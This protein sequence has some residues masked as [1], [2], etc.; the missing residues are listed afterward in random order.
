MMTRYEPVEAA[1]V[2]L[3]RY[4]PKASDCELWWSGSGVRTRLNCNRLEAEIE[5][6]DGPQTPW[7]VVTADGAPVARFPLT[8]GRHRYA[9]LGD[10]GAE[11]EHEI[12]LLRDTEPSE[13]DPGPVKLLAL[14]TDGVP[15]APTARERLVEFIGDSL[16]AGEGTLGPGSAREWRRAW[17]SGQFAFPAMAAELLN[18]DARVLGRG[19]WGAY[20][21]Y[22]G[23]ETHTLGTIYDRLCAG[24]TGGEIAN[25]FENQRPA[26]AVVINLGTNDGSGVKVAWPDDPE[27]GGRRVTECAEV[28]MAMVRARNP[29]AEILWAYGLCGNVMEGPLRKAVERRRAAGDM[30]TRYLALTDCGSDLGSLQHPGIPAHWRAANEIA[31]ALKA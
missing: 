6:F 16:T 31:K 17:I 25:D 9:L 12:A 30:K 21:S 26:D 20:I 18:A 24:V 2:R 15:Q 27:T 29:E 7:M 10:M 8:P 23:D 5:V 22:D 14:Y 19:G 1:F 28:L 3:G 11:A 4:N 13:G